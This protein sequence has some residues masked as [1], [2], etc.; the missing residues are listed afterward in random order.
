M[1]DTASSSTINKSIKH[2]G[3]NIK[4]WE[5]MTAL[6]VGFICK[7]KDILDSD[8]YYKILGRELNGHWNIMDLNVTRSYFNTT[9]SIHPK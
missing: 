8:L 6:E 4:V 7:I 5:C 9:L 2:W 3:G 1:D